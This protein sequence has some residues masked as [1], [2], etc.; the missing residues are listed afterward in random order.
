MSITA[1]AARREFGMLTVWMDSS[2]AGTIRRK[3][4]ALRASLGATQW[5]LFS[6][7]LAESLVLALLGGALGVR[8][9]A[10]LL[11]V[12]VVLLPQF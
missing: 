6:Q 2:A 3:Q 10:M 1:A 5:Q 4:A 7:F 9:A 11:K 12:I 8:L